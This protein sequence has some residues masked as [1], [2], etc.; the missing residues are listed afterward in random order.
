MLSY[1]SKR[2]VEGKKYLDVLL[3]LAGY[4]WIIHP[5]RPSDTLVSNMFKRDKHSPRDLI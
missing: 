3:D 4:K 1:A 2:V 5:R